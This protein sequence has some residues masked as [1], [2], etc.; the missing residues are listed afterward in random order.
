MSFHHYQSPRSYCFEVPVY[1]RA[2]FVNQPLCQRVA[3]REA[4]MSVKL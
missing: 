3:A 1:L 2:S 4:L